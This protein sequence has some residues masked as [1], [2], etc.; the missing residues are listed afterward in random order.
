MHFPFFW[1]TTTNQDTK[2]QNMKQQFVCELLNGVDWRGNYLA[3]WTSQDGI[4][5]RGR[6]KV[7]LFVLSSVVWSL[8][9]LISDKATYRTPLGTFNDLTFYKFYIYVFCIKV[10]DSKIMCSDSLTFASWKK[11]CL[12][13]NFSHWYKMVRWHIWDNRTTHQRQR[14]KLKWLFFVPTRKY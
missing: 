10:F 14:A 3:G 4:K 12:F 2:I 8:S 1:L 5:R 7:T 13:S 6:G 9:M 11:F